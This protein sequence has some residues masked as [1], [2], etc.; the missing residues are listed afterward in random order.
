MSTAIRRRV[1]RIVIAVDLLTL[2]AVA[3]LDGTPGHRSW[4]LTVSACSFA[5]I[6]IAAGAFY[7]GWPGG[8]S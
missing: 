2:I 6:S 4:V 8:R 5:V 1:A 3:L 7:L